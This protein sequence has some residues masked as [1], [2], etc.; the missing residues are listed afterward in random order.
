[1]SSKYVDTVSAMQVI[2]SVFQE[3]DLLDATD[4]FL[5][6]NFIKLYLVVFINYMKLAQKILLLKVLMIF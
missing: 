4:K 5:R 6:M 1:M 2:G 3:P